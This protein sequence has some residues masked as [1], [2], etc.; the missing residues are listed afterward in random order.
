MMTPSN[1]PLGDAVERLRKLDAL[2]LGECDECEAMLAKDRAM[3]LPLID[4]AG[5]AG[6]T[7]KGANG[8]RG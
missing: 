6:P 5:M 2:A 1:D 7:E 8:A 4:N 3:A